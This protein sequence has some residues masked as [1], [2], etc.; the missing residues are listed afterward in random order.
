M[1]IILA[2][3]EAEILRIKIQGQPWQIV[4]KILPGVG[5]WWLTLVILATQ[6]A[7]I[8]KIMV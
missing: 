5:Y 7:E 2:S 6:A 8:R 3:W 1:P 4:P